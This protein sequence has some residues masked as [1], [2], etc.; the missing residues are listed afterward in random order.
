MKRLLALA[1]VT[2]PL[3]ACGGGDDAKTNEGGAAG[4]P[5]PAA[6][7]TM[8]DMPE[9][10][11]AMEAAG[12]EIEAAM[13]EAM[14]EVGAEMEAAIEEAGEELEAAMEELG[15]ALEGLELPQ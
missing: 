1:V 7:P 13:N 12:G 14:E 15:A 3:V 4:N 5:N 9:L 6:M 2:L 11:A 10:G 8:P